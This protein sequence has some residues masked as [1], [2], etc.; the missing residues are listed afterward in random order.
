MRRPVFRLAFVLFGA[1]LVV[2]GGCVPT[3]KSAPTNF[4]ILSAL[5]GAE[6][7][8]QTAAARGR[9]VV[10]VGPVTLADY[11]DRPQFVTRTGRNRLQVAEFHQW[12]EPLE[13]GVPRVIVENLSFLLPTSDVFPLPWRA[14]PPLDYQ[15]G[16]EVTRFDADDAG[17]VSLIARWILIKSDRRRTLLTRK[18]NIMLPA[19]GGSYEH[20]ASAMSKALAGLSREIAA[21]LQAQSK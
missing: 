20:I 17:A 12:G 11:L 18:T 5:P 6:T 3:P 13:D 10:G 15:V 7:K 2:T 19:A 4:Y 21:A 14:T 1:S 8:R 9:T 16:I